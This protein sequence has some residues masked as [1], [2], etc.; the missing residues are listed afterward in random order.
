M[1]G[2]HWVRKV[3]APAKNPMHAT[4]LRWDLLSLMDFFC[5]QTSNVHDEVGVSGLLL[6]LLHTIYVAVAG[7]VMSWGVTVFLVSA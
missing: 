7:E 4:I 1:S 2:C 6:S 5:G 3:A